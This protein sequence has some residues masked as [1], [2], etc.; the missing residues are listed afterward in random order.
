MPAGENTFI[1][2]TFSNVIIFRNMVKWIIYGKRSN[3]TKHEG[4][5]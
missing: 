4:P 3:L 5:S 2:A 1:L